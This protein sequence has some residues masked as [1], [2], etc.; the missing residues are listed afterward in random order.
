MPR[1]VIFTFPLNWVKRGEIGLGIPWPKG[2]GETML[3]GVPRNTLN[4]RWAV[5]GVFYL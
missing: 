2:V 4:A 5:E 3:Q 1:C